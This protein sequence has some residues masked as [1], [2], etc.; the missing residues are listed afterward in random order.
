LRAIGQMSAP[1]L[2]AVIAYVADGNEWAAERLAREPGWAI[3]AALRA[4]DTKAFAAHLDTLDSYEIAELKLGKKAE[5]QLERAG[6]LHRKLDRYAYGAPTVRFSMEDVDQARAAGTVIEF[7]RSRPVI[8]DRAQYRELAKQAIA[9][10]VT[11]LEAKAAAEA[12]KRERRA[13]ARP[14]DPV[15]EAKREHG[16]ALRELADQAHGANLDLGTG[17]IT[18]LATVEPAD[19][20]VARF[21]VYALLGPDYD[22]SP[23]TQ[24]GERV[25]RLAASGMR[26]VVE[27]FRTDVTTTR[28]DGTPGRLR[29]DYGDPRDPAEP[30]KWL[31][32]FIDAAGT[33]G[34]LY[35]RA[36]VV[37]CAE[38][39][40]SRLMLPASQLS[41][42]TRWGSHGDRAAK[43]L[44]KLAGPHLP[45]SLTQLE[46]AVK[47]AHAAQRMAEQAARHAQP[48]ASGDDPDTTS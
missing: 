31:W 30:V 48:P 34:E 38:Q 2:D 45:A 14:A 9:R 24:T 22:H 4:G 20:D 44:R 40:A 43:A 23:Y 36:L 42:P 8:V 28:K 13:A 37:I 6:E 19:M 15:A 46:R 32:K 1:L 18:G 47:R 33:A 27:E 35:G 10:T 11:E 25:A 17:L 21:F 3:D 7:D 12:E 39:H 16:R 26:L 41:A 29:V 5:Q